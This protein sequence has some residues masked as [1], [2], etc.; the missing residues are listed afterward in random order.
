MNTNVAFRVEISNLPADFLVEDDMNKD[1]LRSI[2]SKF[3]TVAGGGSFA[4]YYLLPPSQNFNTTISSGIGT[5][6]ELTQQ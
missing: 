3:G 6:F 4:K 1:L 5:S 2:F